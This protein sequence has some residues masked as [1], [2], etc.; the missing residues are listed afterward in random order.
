MLILPPLLWR[1]IEDR[2]RRALPDEACGLLLGSVRGNEIEVAALASARNVAADPHVDFELDP[3]DAVAAEDG[4]RA[5]GWAIVGVWH[6]HPRGPSSPSL[7]DRSGACAA[8]LTL[9]AVPKPR[10]GI[11]LGAWRCTE[12]GYAAVVV[13]ES[14]STHG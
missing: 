8:W 6:S 7:Q 10:T 4:A 12:H 5:S 11:Q 9:I 2:T 14:F 13:A 1:E 3:L